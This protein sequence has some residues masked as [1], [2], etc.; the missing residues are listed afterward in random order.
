MKYIPTHHIQLYT[1][2]ILHEDAACNPIVIAA[3]GLHLIVNDDDLALGF[4]KAI[5]IVNEEIG[6]AFS[7]LVGRV[8]RSSWRKSACIIEPLQCSLVLQS[9]RLLLLLLSYNL[10]L[11][12]SILH[13]HSRN[14]HMSSQTRLTQ[15]IHQFPSSTFHFQPCRFFVT[16]WYILQSICEA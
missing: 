7:V 3:G 6:G 11:Y 14:T 13:N 12:L 8:S 9:I 1:S 16:P 15:K 2:L 4:S 5:P 10:S